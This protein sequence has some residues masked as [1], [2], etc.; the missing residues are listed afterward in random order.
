MSSSPAFQL[1]PADLLSSPKVAIMTTEEFGAYLKLLCYAWLDADC[2]I[3]DNDDQLASMTKLG[4]GWLKGS[5]AVVRA[6]FE[7]HPQLP[8]RLVNIRLFEERIKQAEWREKCA[9]GGKKSAQTRRTK[10][11]EQLKGSS[12][13]V[14]PPFEGSLKTVSTKSQHSVSSLQ[15]S[16]VPKEEES[17]ESGDRFSPNGEKDS[18]EKQ[19]A[20][21][22]IK[23]PLTGDGNKVA[24]G[25]A[26]LCYGAVTAESRAR[27]TKEQVLAIKAEAKR[28]RESC[29]V[30]KLADWKIWFD[31]SWQG[32]KLAAEGGY[33]KLSHIRE[34]WSKAFP[35]AD[36]D[37]PAS[38]DDQGVVGDL[39]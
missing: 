28:L 6:C 38:T 31:S 33:P 1:Y 17:G 11:V 35:D 23:D 29:D 25:L 27:F 20:A 2:T 22:V 3:P 7:V 18:A 12:R 32:K 39:Y 26:K 34:T 4:E 14:Q 37:E 13:V 30:E 15:S 9:A 8:G 21:K 5:S 19:T 16:D 24:R 36:P 10:A